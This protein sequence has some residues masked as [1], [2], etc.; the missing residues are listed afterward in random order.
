LAQK[1]AT[2]FSPIHSV[3]FRRFFTTT[4]SY[5][6]R[7]SSDQGSSQNSS[8]NSGNNPAVSLGTTA[9][10]GGD[11]PSFLRRHWFSIVF[12]IIFNILLIMFEEMM[13]ESLEWF[14][15]ICD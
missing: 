3:S 13:G 12:V 8:N 11:T 14:S 4:A 9:T 10:A 1:A 5:S 6:S 15:R 2:P 7:Q